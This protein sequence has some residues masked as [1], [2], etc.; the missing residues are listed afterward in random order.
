MGEASRRGR[1]DERVRI[2]TEYR[3]SEDCIR[4]VYDTVFSKAQEVYGRTGHVNHEL[5]GI[6]F[7]GEEIKQMHTMLISAHDQRKIP[8]FLKTMLDRFAIVVHVMEAWLAPPSDIA[9]HAHPERKDIIA[10]TIHT[11]ASVYAATCEVDTSART[12]R[13]AELI[14]PDRLG[15]RYGRELPQKH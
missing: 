6:E 11:Q 3:T 1:P 8:E 13:K 9:P 7:A 2:A 5:V 15:G 10:I 4:N 12:V 14:K